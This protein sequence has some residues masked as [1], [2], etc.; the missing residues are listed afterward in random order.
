MA[1]HN[2][3]GHGFLEP[4]YHEAL[5]IEFPIHKVVY[6][7]EVQL[8]VFYKGQQLPTIYRA[9]FLCFDEIIVE[10]KAIKE[11]GKIEEAQLI[12]YLKATHKPTGLLINFGG[13]SLEYR[14]FSNHFKQSA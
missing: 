7:H 14:R 8:P 9:D 1:V 2:E 3:L 6:Q 5:K 11:L 12:N 4:V 10:I 13:K